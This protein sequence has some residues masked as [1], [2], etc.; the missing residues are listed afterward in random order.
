MVRSAKSTFRPL[1]R[2]RINYRLTLPQMISAGRYQ[3]V[4]S[5]ITLDNFPII[6]GEPEV[7]LGM[8]SFD[9]QMSSAAV[10]ER[11]RLE[12]YDSARIEHL[13]AL[14][15]SY[16]E[17]QRTLPISALASV[18]KISIN[19]L[20]VA[21]LDVTDDDRRC[22]KLDYANFLWHEGHGFLAV[23]SQ[24]ESISSLVTTQR[25]FILLNFWYNL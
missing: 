19:L 15:A 1:V 14:G 9:C 25:A 8:L 10:R 22:L 6:K 21:S 13:L 18:W 5:D 2:F 3:V 16:P 24:I 23:K 7:E 11:L 17:K 20:M 12:S 4:D